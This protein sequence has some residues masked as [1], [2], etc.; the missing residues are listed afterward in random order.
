M[1]TLFCAMQNGNTFLAIAIPQNTE[2]SIAILPPSPPR[3][4]LTEPLLGCFKQCEQKFLTGIRTFITEDYLQMYKNI[5]IITK[6]TNRK[7]LKK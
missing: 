5:T 2:S 1:A 4:P 7:Y 6:G 3:P